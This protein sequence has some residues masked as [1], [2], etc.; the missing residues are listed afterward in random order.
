MTRNGRAK[1]VRHRQTCE[2]VPPGHR[3]PTLSP[4]RARLNSPTHRRVLNI[5]TFLRPFRLT[6]VRARR[7]NPRRVRLKSPGMLV[8]LGRLRLKGH[9]SSN[10]YEPFLLF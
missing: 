5:P 10:T 2:V 4:V 7:G 8:A 6:F 3:G 9:L 1:R